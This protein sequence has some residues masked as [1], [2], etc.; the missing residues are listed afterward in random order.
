MCELPLIIQGELIYFPLKV[1]F[2]PL[3][4]LFNRKCSYP[5]IITAPGETR[6]HTSPYH[7]VFLLELGLDLGIPGTLGISAE[8]IAIDGKL[9]VTVHIVSI[10]CNNLMIWE[11]SRVH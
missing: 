7:P 4:I 6:G 10:I 1:S 5:W 2:I 11:L 3:L 9:G 8:V